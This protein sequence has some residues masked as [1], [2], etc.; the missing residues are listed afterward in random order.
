M[1][2]HA[3]GTQQLDAIEKQLR[4]GRNALTD[5]VRQLEP[6]PDVVTVPGVFIRFEQ[7]H[8]LLNQQGEIEGIGVTGVQHHA[9][10]IDGDAL[11]HGM[12][13]NL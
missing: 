4:I 8:E 6:L 7:R 2:D 11:L 3:V 9:L 10:V 12:V 5:R 13:A 1:L